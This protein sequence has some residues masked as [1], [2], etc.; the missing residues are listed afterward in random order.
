MKDLNIALLGMS[1]NNITSELIRALQLNGV[2]LNL[3]I[4]EKGDFRSNL[5]RIIRK[6]KAAGLIATASRIAYA[7]KARLFSESSTN[8]VDSLNQLGQKTHVLTNPNGLEC[9]QLLTDN[10]I[11]VL[12]LSTDSII[13]RVIFGI[14]KK[15]TLN[16]HPGRAPQYR[17][18]GGLLVEI[19]ETG[20]GSMT[21][22]QINEGIDTG[23]VFLR[24]WLPDE[25]WASTPSNRDY[26]IT[27]FQAYM[28]ASVINM[29][30]KEEAIYVDT[31]LERSNMS[32]GVSS[33]FAKKVWTE[34][35]D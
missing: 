3:V 22:H 16:A 23:P 11:D 35:F 34:L 2:N 5:R 25:F 12:L 21:V 26:I 29:I 27:H 9:Q 32:R 15:A 19:A 30:A 33:K 14:P 10:E 20:K 17:G 8:I 24:K 13:K 18:L 28:F 31:F 7:L 1:D 4:L 6:I